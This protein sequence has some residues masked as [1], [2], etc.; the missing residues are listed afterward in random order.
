MPE[1]S[2]LLSR[3]TGNTLREGL[4]LRDDDGEHQRSDADGERAGEDCDDR[5]LDELPPHQSSTRS[6]DR[7]PDGD[8]APLPLA[9]R[10]ERFATFA[11]AIT[12]RMPIAPSRIQSGPAS[13]PSSSS[14]SGTTRGLN[15]SM[16]SR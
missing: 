11:Q 15:R 12:S 14:F 10:Q 13:G 1:S 4:A 6:A 5:R 9:A 8:V 16:I 3:G 2:A 7:A